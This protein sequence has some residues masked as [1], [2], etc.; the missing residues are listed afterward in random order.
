MTAPVSRSCSGV[1]T[2]TGV[3]SMQWC[4]RERVNFSTTTL[5]ITPASVLA[6]WHHILCALSNELTLNKETKAAAE[7]THDGN[8]LET[9]GR[10]NLVTRSRG[11]MPCRYLRCMNLYVIW[12][13][14]GRPKAGYRIRD[15]GDRYMRPVTCV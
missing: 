4:S 7:T 11:E 5:S 1:M 12:F 3:L 8:F 14:T 13:R 15:R 6:R 10:R 2:S 9:F